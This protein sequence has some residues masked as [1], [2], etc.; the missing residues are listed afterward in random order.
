MPVIDLTNHK[1]G[2]LTV[3]ERVG[4]SYSFA[5]WRCLC[6]CGNEV[7]VDSR[8]LRS[9][10]TQSCGCLWREK[11]SLPGHGASLRA[12]YR[13]YEHEAQRRNLEWSLSLEDFEKITSSNCYYCNVQPSQEGRRKTRHGKEYQTQAY[14]YNGIDRVDNNLGYIAS[15]C[16]P[17]CKTC[18]LAKRTMP[19]NEFII[20]IERVHSNLRTKELI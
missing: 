9:G 4:K 12:K 3:I 14:I 18:N 20:W 10:N 7:V 13:S 8:S 1:Y 16:V 15:N 11:M 5:T 6:D 2:R 19:I 17:C